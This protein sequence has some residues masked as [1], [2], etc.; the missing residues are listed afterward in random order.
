M[1]RIVTAGID[2]VPPDFQALSVVPLREKQLRA[3]PPHSSLER[4]GVGGRSPGEWEETDPPFQAEGEP[5]AG[6]PGS[7]AG[8]SMC[9]CDWA[10][11]ASYPNPCKED[12]PCPPTR[13]CTTT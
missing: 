2:L 7:E 8:K 5:K 3:G 4:S 11:A 12:E 6:R 10:A 9:C 1:G 13:S